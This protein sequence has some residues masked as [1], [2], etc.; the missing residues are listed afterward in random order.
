MVLVLNYSDYRYRK[1]KAAM[2]FL[3]R[4]IRISIAIAIYIDR[5]DIVCTLKSSSLSLYIPF[6][7]FLFFMRLAA[8]GLHV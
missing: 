8:L 5:A 4:S 6:L 3:R 7:F 2:V 1:S